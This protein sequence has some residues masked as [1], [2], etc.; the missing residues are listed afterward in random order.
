MRTEIVFQP[1]PGRQGPLPL[2]AGYATVYGLVLHRPISKHARE[3]GYWNISDPV[4]GGLVA[5]GEY[6]GCEGAVAGLVSLVMRYT[7]YPGGFAGALADARQQ[8][9]G[10]NK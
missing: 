10:A 7:Q 8:W 2:T 9:A 3:A 1:A 4:T 5:Y 6:P